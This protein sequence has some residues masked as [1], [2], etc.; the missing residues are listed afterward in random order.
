MASSDD[1]SGNQGVEPR[2]RPPPKEAEPPFSTA[3][4]VSIE[5]E[6]AREGKGDDGQSGSLLQRKVLI[7][8]LVKARGD[9]P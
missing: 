4:L 3:R 1:R 8:K 9:E 6:R 7:R 5:A 2:H